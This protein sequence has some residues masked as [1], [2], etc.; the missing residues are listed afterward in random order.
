MDRQ[1]K[2]VHS[3]EGNK[4]PNGES[5]TIDFKPGEHIVAC[6]VDRKVN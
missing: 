2:V 3:L 1:G 6:A 4:E 5:I